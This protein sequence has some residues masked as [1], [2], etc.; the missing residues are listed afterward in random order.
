ML[1]MLLLEEILY[2]CGL[3]FFCH[4]PFYYDS[5]QNLLAPFASTSTCPP[6][7]TVSH[8][9]SLFAASEYYSHFGMHKTK[10]AAAKTNLDELV[11][12]KNAQ[13][14]EFEELT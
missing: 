2:S 3:E 8:P 11:D 7:F 10:S 6:I 5:T 12:I 4:L 14:L 13:K 9:L 1:D